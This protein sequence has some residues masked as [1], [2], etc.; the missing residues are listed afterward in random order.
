MA[1]ETG[2]LSRLD[3][4]LA[5]YLAARME[6]NKE[7]EAVKVKKEEE[8]EEVKKEEKK[9]EEKKKKKRKND[10][11]HGAR[12]AIVCYNCQR[13]GHKAHECPERESRRQADRADGFELARVRIDPRLDALELGLAAQ[14]K[15]LLALENRVKKEAE[16]KAREAEKRAEKAEKKVEELEK[17]VKELGEKFAHVEDF[18]AKLPA[19]PTIQ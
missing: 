4:E 10:K 5:Q 16:K 15:S 18:I 17:K 19:P 12:E 8:E 2:T 1:P 9:E 14:Q 7:K 11:D 13:M 3:K 6:A